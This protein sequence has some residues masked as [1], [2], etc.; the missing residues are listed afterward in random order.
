[1]FQ[2]PLPMHVR[3]LVSRLLA[4]VALVVTVLVLSAPTAARA[5]GVAPAGFIIDGRGNGHGR[6]MSQ[7]GALGWATEHNKSWR[8]II[9][10]YYRNGV[11]SLSRMT[12]ADNPV[13]PFGNMTVRLFEDYDASDKDRIQVAVVSDTGTLGAN[14]VTSDSNWSTLVAREKFGQTNVW[15][16]W[17]AKVKKCVTGYANLASDSAFTL[18]NANYSPG[19]RAA[20]VFTTPKWNDSNA[21]VPRDLIGVCDPRSNGGAGSVQYYRGMIL[22]ANGTAGEN[23]I[24]NMV[25]LDL[26]VRGVVPRESPASWGDA[27]DGKG[28]NAL[29]AQAVAARSYAVADAGYS[30]TSRYSYAKTCDTQNCQVYMGAARRA[31]ANDP[32]S[33]TLEDPRSTQAVIDTGPTTDRSGA[34]LGGWVV[35]N[36]FGGIM[37]TEFTSSN[38]GRTTGTTFGTRDDPGDNIESNPY[39]TW[40][41]TFTQA[42]MKALYPT[43]GT[44]TSI[45]TTK[46]SPPDA[47]S[48]I[49]G[50]TID[51]TITGTSGVVTRSAWEFRG[52]LDLYAPWFGVTPVLPKDYT[53]PE[54]GP[55]LFV[56]DSVMASLYIG[57]EYQTIIASAYPASNYQ[58]LTYRCMIGNCEP[59]FYPDQRDG[60]RVIQSEAT[61]AMAVIGLGYNDSETSYGAE[62][63][64][65]IGLLTE[66]GVRRIVFINMSQRGNVKYAAMNAA[67]AARAAGNPR[68]TV[69]DWNAASSGQERTRWFESDGVHLKSTGRT[70]FAQFV[71]NQL[72]ALRR[73]EK[74][75]MTAQRPAY[76]RNLPLYINRPENGWMLVCGLQVKLKQQIDPDMTIDCEF[77]P[78]TAAAVKTLETRRKLVVDGIVDNKVWRILFGNVTPYAEPRN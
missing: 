58:A 9:N 15:E 67:L 76:V 63:D 77:G 68:V 46:A 7:Y 31:S 22:A 17:G 27:A 72:D 38:G 43:V 1:M 66:K 69:F 12:S 4:A 45:N 70:K 78:Q 62:V 3:L 2:A 24:V 55:V 52:D 56:G 8:E 49:G 32:Y 50:Y 28:M 18:I 35:R 40:S 59:F 54:V 5:D 53:D 10:F 41:R 25:P 60:L 13:L 29:R 71:R 19:G 44:I 11:N 47:L 61:P 74:I 20:V 48:P 14:G 21:T 37:R 65:I 42:Q 16:I 30:A 51:V 6:G 34:Y 73:A 36:P 23:R 33:T 26:Y 75:P 57:Q 64:Q 39:Y